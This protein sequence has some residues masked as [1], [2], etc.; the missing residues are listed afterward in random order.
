MRPRCPNC[1]RLVGQGKN[2]DGPNY[3]P[4]CR[5]LFFV[6]PPESIPPWILGV[7]VILMANSQITF[8]AF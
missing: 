4:Q 7:V 3:C 2:V 8:H 1:C 5:K 6:P